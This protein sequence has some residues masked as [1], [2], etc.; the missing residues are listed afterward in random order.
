VTPSPA[1]WREV[2]CVECGKFVAGIDFGQRC[3]EC[4]AR[5]A[6]RA[7]AIASR[8]AIVAT[9]L[10]ALWTFWQLPRSSLGRW[11]AGLGIG[12]TYFLVRLITRRIAME[13]L[14]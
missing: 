2:P 14:P 13:A 9:I 11:Y 4:Q 6:R 5:R 7:S 10:M 12:A 8:A 3:T 1:G